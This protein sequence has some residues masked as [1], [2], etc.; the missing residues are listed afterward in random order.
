MSDTAVGARKKGLLPLPKHLNL[1]PV[2]SGVRVIQS[3][4]VCVVM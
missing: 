2:L 4:V 3:S 1:S